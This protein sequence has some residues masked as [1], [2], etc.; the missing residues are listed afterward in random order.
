MK[1]VCFVVMGFGKKMDYENNKE[2]DLDIVYNKVIKPLFSELHEDYKLIRGDEISGSALIDTSMYALLMN[3]DLV[4][5][6]LTTLNPNALYELG[7]RHAVR[8]FSTIIMAQDSCKIPFDLSHSRFLKYDNYGEYL[9]DE[10]AHSI[11]LKLK[12]FVEYSRNEIT[13]S[14]MYTY[15]SEASLSEEHYL[16]IVNDVENRN[17]TISSFMTKAQQSMRDSNFIG[18]VED[19]CHLTEMLPNND[20]VKQQHALATYKAMKPNKTMA[21]ENALDIMKQLN[22]KNSLDHETLGITGSIY[23]R[24]FKL[25][26]NY[27][28]LAEATQLYQRGYVLKSDYYNGE[29]YANCLILSVG[30]PRLHNERDFLMYES[31]KTYKEV[32]N[33]INEKIGSNEANYWMFATLS[34]C[35]YVE[36]N[37]KEYLRNLEIFTEKCEGYWEVESLKTTI[38]DITKMLNYNKGEI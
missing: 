23:K 33:L 12:D 10:E 28:Y 4:I 6:D 15:F 27:D 38:E 31:K 2:V 19:W 3:A 14:P 30:D 16:E 24:L 17:E 35:N 29:N 9:E 20:Y 18:A 32:L 36:G 34:I 13:D 5:A 22:P 8:P 25:N 21:L 1:K 11:I 26:Q 37:Q 7:I